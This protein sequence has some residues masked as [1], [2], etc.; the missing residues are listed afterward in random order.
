[1][2]GMFTLGSGVDG[3]VAVHLA[4]RGEQGIVARGAA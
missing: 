3:S 2:G 1:M 4:H